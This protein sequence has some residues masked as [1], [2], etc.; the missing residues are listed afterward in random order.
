MIRFATLLLMTSFASSANAQFSSPFAKNNATAPAAGTAA[1]ATPPDGAAQD[2]LMQR[3]IIAQTR[4]MQ[5]QTLFAKAFGLADQVQL[6]EAE[7][8]ALSSGS[9]DVKGINRATSVTTDAQALIDTK[10]A[11]EPALSAESKLHYSEGLVSL[12]LAV[13]ETR[14]LVTEASAF[15]NGLR[16]G[17]AVQ[18]AMMARKMAVGAWIAKATP[19]HAKNLYASTKSAFTFAKRAKVKTPPNADSMLDSLTAL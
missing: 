18:V 16:S 10:L 19:G 3:F 13:N 7:Q 5:A 1:V 8:L 12:L 17:N 4:S 15:A 14:L 2:A 9:V 11:A 6:L